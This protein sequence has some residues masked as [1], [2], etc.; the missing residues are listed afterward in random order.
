M[1]PISCLLRCLNIYIFKLVHVVD[2]RKTKSLS[3]R[4]KNKQLNKK[5]CVRADIEC[6]AVE[7]EAINLLPLLKC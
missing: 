7:E 6:S 3:L 4:A 1:I 5:S 2:L